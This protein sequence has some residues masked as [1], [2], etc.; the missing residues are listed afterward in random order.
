MTLI[1]RSLIGAS[2]LSLA[3]CAYGPAIAQTGV[4]EVLVVATGREANLQ[5]VPAA[6]TAIDTFTLE[7]VGIS[8]L[9][10]LERIAPSF[11]LWS[12][13]STTQGMV[14]LIRGIG[15][16]GNNAG[17]ESAV[18]IFVDGIYRSRPATALSLFQG[19]ER[20]EVLRGPQGTLFGRN[21]SAGAVSLFTMAPDFNFATWGS[22]GFGD[23]SFYELSG[24]ANIPLIEDKAALRFDGI[25]QSRDGYIRDV[26]TGRKIN[27][28]DRW[29]LRGQALVDIS[30]VAS[31]RLI[32][33]ATQTDEHC[34]ATTPLIYGPTQF[35][36]E[37]I[38][39]PNATL[40]NVSDTSNLLERRN[41]DSEK[42]I[43]VF[44]PGRS[45]AEAVDD[46]GASA[47]LGWAFDFADLTSITAYRDWNATRSQDADFSLL[48]LA[49]RDGQEIRFQTF[50]QE[51]RLQGEVGRFDWLAGAFYGKEQLDTTDRIRLGHDADAY[52]NGVVQFLTTSILGAPFE[53]YDTTFGDDDHPFPD[54]G[55]PPLPPPAVPGTGGLDPIPSLFYAAGLD[56]SNPLPTSIFEN[57]YLNLPSPAGSGQQHDRWAVNTETFAAFTHNEIAVG[58]NLTFAVGLR[59]SHEQKNLTANLLSLSPA[60]ENLQAIE[61]ATGGLVDAML[62]S[63]AGAALNLACNPAINPVANGTWAGNL[64]DDAWSGT[65]SLSYHFGD[66]LMVYG[67]YARGFKSG[68]FNVDRAGFALKPSLLTSA[69]LNTDQLSFAPEYTDAYELGMKS[70]VLD[71]RANLNVTLFHESIS[72]FQLNAFNGTS[73]T[74]RNVPSLISRGVEVDVTANLLDGLSV[75]GGAVYNDAFYDATVVFNPASPDGNTVFKNTSLDHAPKW[76]VTGAVTYEWDLFEAISARLHLNG[77]WNSSYRNQTLSRDPLGRTDQEAYA[78]FNARASV[79]SASGSW[80][81]SFWVNNLAD[82]FYTVGAF[83]AP[84]QPGT[85]L[86]YPGEP[87]M[88]GITFIARY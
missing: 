58:E 41:L 14:A 9:S 81:A 15:T 74:T 52:V 61:S 35:V 22:A 65:S 16:S 25:Y 33:D 17:F 76:A 49:Y 84:L 70:S 24:G 36:I 8:D 87:R 45:Y 34:C 55:V 72:D 43:T 28:R 47:E 62:A 75:Q 31:L 73:F 48:D 27:D 1:Q 37:A 7:N 11:R 88:W 10:K 46:W 63:D 20:V 80:L 29:L 85:Y 3:V 26:I 57:L 42:R 82:T 30:P 78:V 6:V 12:G 56:P 32:V 86:I 51:M 39:G 68:G 59:Y 40:P 23:F 38:A 21:T 54:I 4:S 83:E 64:S 79:G 18:G 50:T 2:F 44:T 67:S 66:N 13:E 5:D 60:C 77:R 53:L 71:S 69:T 19:L